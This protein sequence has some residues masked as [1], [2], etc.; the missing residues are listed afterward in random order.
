MSDSGS[1]RPWA[2]FYN[3]PLV[4]AHS[5]SPV[6]PKKEVPVSPQRAPPARSTAALLSRERIGERV[7][8]P[9]PDAST[10]ILAQRRVVITDL[11]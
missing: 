4:I 9:P 1:F 8:H 11:I 10:A 6:S 7:G 5:S 2:P 3:H